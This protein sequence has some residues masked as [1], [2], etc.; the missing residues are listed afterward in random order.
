MFVTVLRWFECV[1]LEPFLHPSLTFIKVKN[2]K[3]NISLKSSRLYI[4]IFQVN[5][6]YLQ[7]QSAFQK[8]LMSETPDERVDKIEKHENITKCG[9]CL[10]SHLTAPI[11]S[12]FSACSRH[13]SCAHTFQTHFEAMSVFRVL[14]HSAVQPVKVQTRVAVAHS[15]VWNVT[16][17]HPVSKASN[18]FV[19]N[20]TV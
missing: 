13:L 3:G 10:L 12:F 11:S 9:Q 20:L 5:E 14:I 8:R 2:N 6:T 16:E 15:Q 1:T 18:F 7:I 19:K 17:N 4:I